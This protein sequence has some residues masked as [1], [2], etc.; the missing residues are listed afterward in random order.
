L[1]QT[2]IENAYNAVS[3]KIQSVQN[4]AEFLVSQ[5]IWIKALTK[6]DP[7]AFAKACESPN[8]MQA[9]VELTKSLL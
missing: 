2:D 4:Q 9:L 6:K 8:A 1:S 3:A 7:E 5:P